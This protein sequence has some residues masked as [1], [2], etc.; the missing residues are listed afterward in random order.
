[1]NVVFEVK[2]QVGNESVGSL[3]TSSAGYNLIKIQLFIILSYEHLTATRNRSCADDLCN[4]DLREFN[5]PIKMLR[6][7]NIESLQLS[8]FGKLRF[9]W[10]TKEVICAVRSSY[11]E[12]YFNQ[13]TLDDD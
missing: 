9:D 8:R 2:V 6:T 13:N 1:M 10:L 7:S 5:Q 11:E 4:F 3:N 12:L